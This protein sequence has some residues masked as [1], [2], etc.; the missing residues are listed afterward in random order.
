MYTIELTK[1]ARKA[2][3]KLPQQIRTQIY[4]KLKELAES[5]NNTHLNIKALKGY[6][7]YFRL[8]V[9]NYRVVYQLIHKKLIIEVINIGHRKEVYR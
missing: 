2:Y 1:T 3:L 9:N 7:G 8:R 5:P 4:S 6:K